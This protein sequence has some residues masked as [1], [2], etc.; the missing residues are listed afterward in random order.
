M[1]IQVLILFSKLKSCLHILCTY[2]YVCMYVGRLCYFI[3]CYV[4]CVCVCVCIDK[5]N[6]ECHSDRLMSDNTPKM[7]A[8][9]TQVKSCWGSLN[10][11][12]DYFCNTKGSKQ[13]RRKRQPLTWNTTY[14]MKHN[15]II[16]KFIKCSRVVTA[17]WDSPPLHPSPWGN[18]QYSNIC[19]R[20]LVFFEAVLCCWALPAFC[21]AGSNGVHCT[22]ILHLTKRWFSQKSHTTTLSHF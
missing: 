20:V 14:S 11:W 5:M 13:Q 7:A 19:G 16:F 4:L 3:L 22:E 8:G 15:A 17:F 18:V 6:M 12:T 21:S 10:T 1:K 2:M 9:L